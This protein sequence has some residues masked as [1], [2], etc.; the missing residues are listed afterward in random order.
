MFSSFSNAKHS[1]AELFDASGEKTVLKDLT[2][3]QKLLHNTAKAV[4]TGLESGPFAE[5][6][7]V[8]ISKANEDYAEGKTKSANFNDIL[9]NWAKDFNDPTNGQ[10][11][12]ALGFLQ[13]ILK[14]L[15]N[16]TF[17]K[18]LIYKIL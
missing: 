17:N 2:R 8:A 11:N 5:N 18:R 3:S 15:K 7:Q 10:N 14:V 16:Q 12:I 6:M 4:G 1:V 13:G 9:N